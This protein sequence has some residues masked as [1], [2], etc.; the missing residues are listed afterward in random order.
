M[1]VVDKERYFKGEGVNDWERY[2]WV[3]RGFNLEEMGRGRGT[4]QWFER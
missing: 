4:E 3:T 2:A 1:C